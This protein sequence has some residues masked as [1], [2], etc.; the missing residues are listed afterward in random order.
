MYDLP[1]QSRVL[2][3]LTNYV[4]HYTQPHISYIMQLA[5]R[6]LDDLK[7]FQAHGLTGKSL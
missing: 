3:S 2:D 6:Y 7:T 1:N 4:Q 5:A